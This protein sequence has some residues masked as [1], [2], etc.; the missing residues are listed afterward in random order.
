MAVVIDEAVELVKAY[1]T[2]ESGRLRQRHPVDH[3]RRHRIVLAL[4]RG[5][6]RLGSGRDHGR[7][8]N[9]VSA[10]VVLTVK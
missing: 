7:R 9:D 6:T 4:T 1:S 2:D 3:R 10:T 5:L 8:Q